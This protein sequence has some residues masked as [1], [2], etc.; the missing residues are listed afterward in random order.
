MTGQVQVS[1]QFDDEGTKLFADITTRN[2]GKEVAIFLDNEAISIPRVNEP[3][4]SGSAVIN[5]NFTLNEARIL[6][7]RLNSGALPVPVE[8]L[9]Q[10]KVDATL[11]EDSLAKS[12]KA[13]VAGLLLVMLFM[14]I[15]YRLPG[16]LSVF[17]LAVYALVTLALFKVLGVTLTLAGIAG[18][19]LSIGMAV[20]EEVVSFL[21]YT[22]RLTGTLVYML[23]QRWDQKQLLLQQ[24]Q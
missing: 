17:S 4:T 19:I 2:S 1:L 8:L 21:S 13:G 23:P 20:E 7:Q 10:Q 9:S 12:F 16:L 11:G 22:R 24:V 6:S 14:V 3:I 18:F 15:Y 5:G